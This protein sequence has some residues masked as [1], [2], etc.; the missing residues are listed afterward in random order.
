M[1][2]ENMILIGAIVL[3]AVVWYVA[4]KVLRTAFHKGFDAIHNAAVRAEEEK[5]PPKAESLADR[6]NQHNDVQKQ[7]TDMNDETE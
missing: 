4:H 7:N 3:I 1:T 6:Y 5:N 2:R